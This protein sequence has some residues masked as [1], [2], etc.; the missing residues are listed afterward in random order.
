MYECHITID[1]VLDDAKFGE[2]EWTCHLSK[3]R[4][5]RLIKVTGE[6]SKRDQFMTGHGVTQDELSVRAIELIKRLQKEGY[7]IKRYKIELIVVDSRTGD[8]WNLLS[9]S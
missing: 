2:L 3:F 7:T 5:A 4:V 6:E 8:Q 9:T 1:P